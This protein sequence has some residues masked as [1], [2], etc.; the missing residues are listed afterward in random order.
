[1][2]GN[3]KMSGDCLID[4]SKLQQKNNL[5][6]TYLKSDGW[7]QHIE[8]ITYVLY[9]S[10]KML[11]TPVYYNGRKI[12]EGKKIRYRHVFE[13]IYFIFYTKIAILFNK[14]KLSIK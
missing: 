3:E 13:I 2:E 11:E 8:I 10:K 1:M 5:P 6:I 4:Q 7:G 12:S 9:N 14:K